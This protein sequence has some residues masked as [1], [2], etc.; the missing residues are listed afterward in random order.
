MPR[1]VLHLAG[2]AVSPFWAD[3]SRL[4]ARDCLAATA[5]AARWTP[6]IAYVSPDRTWRF[7]ASLEAQDV[8]VAPAM[9]I[10]EAVRVLAAAGVDVALPQMFDLPGM[11]VYRGLL[12]LLGV[13]YVGNTPDTMAV[14]ADKQRARALV[15]AAGVAVP[16]GEV[17]RACGLPRL[18]PPV[19]VKPVDA[20]NS[21][22]VS[23]VREPG[24]MP[25]A[26]E[27]ALQ[28][29]RAALVERYVEAGRE[30]RCGLLE[31]GGRLVDLPLEEYPVDPVAK[32]I[33]DRADKLASGGD[34]M[35]LVAKD[36]DHAWIVDEDD[37]VVPVV[38]AAARLAYTALGCRHYGLFDF[39][40]DPD[41]R[42]WFLEAGLYCSFAAQ[43]VLAVMAAAA[44][45][46]VDVLLRD[47]VDEALGT[48]A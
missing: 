5:D 46:P 3:L 33:R 23:L 7:P 2:S 10:E 30:V 22:G 14:A 35:R 16:E 25:A 42:P 39:R 6:L 47:A 12:D 45:T 38:R 41:G 4:Y 13:P 1:T 31:R 26:L 11:T 17:V 27:A 21:L 8:A 32:P 9:P 20:D 18:D 48:G 44:G 15:A 34:A 19:V 24:A 29:S 36:R 40:V 43:S 28:H 37:P